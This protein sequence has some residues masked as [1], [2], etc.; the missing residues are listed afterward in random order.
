MNKYSTEKIRNIGLFGHQGAGKTSLTEAIL[1]C[2]GVTDRLGKVENGNTVTDFDPDEVERCMSV[3]SAV[4]PVEWKDGKIN[5]LD[6]PGFFDFVSES[7]GALRVCD[8]A[9]LVAAANSGTEVGLEKT[10]DLCQGKSKP[11]LLFVN[12]MDKENANFSHLMDEAAQNLKGASVVPVQLPIGAAESFSGVVDLIEQKAYSF[13]AK[14]VPSEI[15]IPADMTDEIEEAREKLIEAAAEATDELTEKYFETMELSTEEVKEG[16]KIVVAK[17]SVVP[18]LCGSSITLAGISLLLDAVQ[19]YAPAPVAAEIAADANE[20]EVEITPDAAA[21]VAALVFK[22][23]SDPY[24]GKI[25]YLRVISGTLRSDSVLHNLNRGIDEKIGSLLS[26]RGKSQE[27]ISEAVAGDI[28]A[29]GRLGATATG[30]TL[31]DASRKVSLKGLELPRPFYSRAIRAKSKAD[32]DKLSAN[33]QRLLQEDPTLKLERVEE[34]HQTIITGI[35]DVQLDLCVKR[36]KRLGVDVELYDRKIPYRE[37]LKGTVQETYRHKKQAGGRGQF[38]QVSIEISGLKSGEGFIFEDNIVGG[39]VSK[40]Y[41]PA[42]EKGVR[43]AMENGI[44]SGNPVVDVKVRLFDGKMHEVDS[45]DMAFQIAGGMAFKEGAPKAKP[46]ILEPI[47]NVEVL[48]PDDYMGDVIGDLNSKRG[49]INGM[50]PVEGGLQCVK[51]QVPLAEMQ[52]YAIDLRSITQGRGSFSQ[53]FDHY[54]QTPS[55]VADKVI[56]DAKAAAEQ[57]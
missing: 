44:L 36:L 9:I 14:G 41:I 49:R 6:T 11:R 42:V 48:V 54:E 8:C 46:I 20:K 40:N 53:E 29:V 26:I 37:T 33:L 39:V 56:A 17:G 28:V 51:A 23:S 38:A 19:H 24:V 18:A 10:W 12:K 50:E 45:S 55:E 32:E 3:F 30:D 43:K 4:A 1:Y 7:L 21:P 34:T 5:V 35:G 13:D 47:V 25:S 15:A 31:S 22:T 52:R 27:K 57:A 2:A 16:L